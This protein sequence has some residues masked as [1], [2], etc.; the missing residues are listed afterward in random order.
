MLLKSTY[1][2]D[3]KVLVAKVLLQSVGTSDDVE[4]VEDLVSHNVAKSIYQH[5]LETNVKFSQVHGPPS[6]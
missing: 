6:T 1:L 4:F 2:S 5:L 3:T